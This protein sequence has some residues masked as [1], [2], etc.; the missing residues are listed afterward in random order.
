MSETFEIIRLGHLGDGIADSA[1]GPVMVPLALA[2]ERVIAEGDGRQRRLVKVEQ[3]SAD[4][5]DPFCPHFLRCGGCQLQHLREGV[6]R[7]WKTGLLQVALERAGISTAIEPMIGF[8]PASRR[9]AVFSAIHTS[10]GMVL[11]FSERGSNHVVDIPHCPILVPAL[12]EAMAEIRSLAAA[13]ASAAPARAGAMRVS[14]LACENGLDIAFSHPRLA[15][16]WNPAKLA[17]LAARHEA[18]RSFLRISFNGEVL[19]ERERPFLKAGIARLTPPPEGFVQAVGAAE[20]AMADLVT[21]HLAGC[22]QTADLFCG[23]GAFA[24]R[25]AQD[26]MVV[27]CESDGAAMAALDRA[28]RETGGR[29]KTIRQE[30]R[31]LFRRPLMAAEM[32]KIDGAVFDPPRAGAEAQARELA[33]SG[34]GRIAAVS[35]NPQTLARD[36]A[37]LIDSG[38]RLVSLTPIDQFAFSPHLEAVALL[39]RGA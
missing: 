11:G 26:S 14:V 37:I 33:A 21:S 9:R 13:F 22:R 38:Y 3:A 30:R 17:A 16:Q 19:H 36:L 39:E 24:L 35:C 28:W 20:E 27:A 4:R 15:R 18:S 25:L 12:Q 6:Y 34:I 29:L 32:K 31:D 10:G 23:S 2:G 1:D 5:I 7:E 8:D